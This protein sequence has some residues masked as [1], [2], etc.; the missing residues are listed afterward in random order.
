VRLEVQEKAYA[1]SILQK[2]AGGWGSAWTG[3]STYREMS[4]PITNEKKCSFTNKKDEMC[5]I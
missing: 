3:S 5:I 4:Y 1:C 2:E